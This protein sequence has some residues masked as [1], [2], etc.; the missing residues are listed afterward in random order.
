MGE[1]VVADGTVTGTGVVLAQRIEQVAE[2]SGVCI[3]GAVYETVPRRVRLEYRNLG[4]MNF[5]GFD[6]PIRVYSA[7]LPDG[8]QVPAPESPRG[9]AVSAKDKPRAERPSIVVMPFTTAGA[10]PAQEAFA[11]GDRKSV[12]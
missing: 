11:D 8:S 12:V 7:A 9:P 1:V 5:K 4:E 3:Q 6:E 10:D 2:H